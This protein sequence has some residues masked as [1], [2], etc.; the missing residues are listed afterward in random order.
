MSQG[1]KDQAFGEGQGGAWGLS[2]QGREGNALW[3]KVWGSRGWPF[4]AEWNAALVLRHK[5]LQSVLL[6]KI[7]VWSETSGGGSLQKAK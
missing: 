4:G 1:K 2:P 3:G 7:S 5:I 6:G